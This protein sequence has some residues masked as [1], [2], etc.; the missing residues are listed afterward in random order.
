MYKVGHHASH[1][2]TLETGGLELMTDP[3]LAAT[4]PVDETSAHNPK[5]GSPTGWDMPFAPLL[6]SLL[7][8]SKG[9]VPLQSPRLSP[10]EWKD[11]EKRCTVTSDYVE[12]AIAEPACLKKKT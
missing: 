12:L 1:D 11:F 6:Q 9:R 10:E 4:I 3:E 7:K 8:K 5:D 2:A